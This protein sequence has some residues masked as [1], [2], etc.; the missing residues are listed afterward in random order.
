MVEPETPAPGC[1]RVFRW[2]E[3]NPSSPWQETFVGEPCFVVERFDCRPGSDGQAV[4]L[5]A[6]DMTQALGRPAWEKYAIHVEVF[7]A[8]LKQQPQ[9]EKLFKT[10]LEQIAFNVRI[11]NSDAHAR[12][13]SMLHAASGI[14]VSPLYD[15]VLMGMCAKR[16]QLLSMP[17][18][19][20]DRPKHE[21]AH[22]WQAE[23]WTCKLDPIG[24]VSW[25]HPLPGAP[26]ST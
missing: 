19:W 22:V 10:F 17:V 3:R 12:D 8:V 1:F 13:Y 20:V 21:A 23:A 16:D 25:W 24:Y 15:V 7:I 6:E 26:S 5:H 9:V 18:G 2:L 11:G 4:R 14:E